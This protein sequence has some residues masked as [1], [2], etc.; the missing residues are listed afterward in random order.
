MIK[1]YGNAAQNV[2]QCAHLSAPMNL[3]CNGIKFKSFL[4]T[5]EA[6]KPQ[7]VV[8]CGGFQTNWHSLWTTS[9]MPGDL[10]V[11]QHLS[12]TAQSVSVHKTSKFEMIENGTV[13][14]NQIQS[15]TL[16][17]EGYFGLNVGPE[18]THS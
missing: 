6:G 18:K 8:I 12:L 7:P 11:H 14:Q 5:I 9:R 1:K 17:L 2:F 15:K 10:K 13:F 3:Y 16:L 4:K